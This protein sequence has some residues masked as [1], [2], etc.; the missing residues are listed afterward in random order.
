MFQQKAKKEQH[1]YIY[2]T[3]EATCRLELVVYYP[4]IGKA[5]VCLPGTFPESFGS[6]FY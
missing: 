5:S 2:G 1:K 4:G 3:L 6:D